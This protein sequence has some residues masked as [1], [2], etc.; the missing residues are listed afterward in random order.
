MELLR[1]N[2]V[3]LTYPPGAE[4]R[5][6]AFYGGVLGLQR[7]EKPGSLNHAGFW[8]AAGESQI[9]LR[10]E[11]PG[12]TSARHPAFEVPDLEAAREDL[13]RAGIA[14][15]DEAD[16]PGWRRFSFR[17]PFGNRIEIMSAAGGDSK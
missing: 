15:R 2:H 17:D 5:A 12:P 7:L 1:L 6:E 9:H 14:C 16:V 10:P 3:Q 13:E 11:E 8:F 4:P